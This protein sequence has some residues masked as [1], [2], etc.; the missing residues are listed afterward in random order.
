M[1]MKQRLIKFGWVLC[2]A[3]VTAATLAQQGP[4][5]VELRDLNQ[6]P[7][8]APDAGDLGGTVPPL[9]K[10]WVRIEVRYETRAE[11]LD[12]VT[13][14]FFA[15]VGKGRAEQVLAGELT[16]VNLARG[17]HYSAMFLHPNV[18]QRFG[19]G[20]VNAVA[21]QIYSQNKLVAQRG[22]PGLRPRWWENA[23]TVGGLLVAP[24]NSPWAPVAAGRYDATK[25][26]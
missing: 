24:Q 23:K 1:V 13:V 7:L 10:D 11:W 14:K 18:V 25:A 2:W 20:Q 21:V 6:R 17:T 26:P 9:N 8:R 22:E 5:V 4:T 16:H 3:L 15:S 12:E 19:D